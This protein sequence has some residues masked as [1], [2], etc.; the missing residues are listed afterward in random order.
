MHTTIQINR[1]EFLKLFFNLFILF[2]ILFIPFPFHIYPFQET[3]TEVFFK[4]TL[5]IVAET[6]FGIHIT[7]PELSSDSTFM[8]LLVWVLFMLSVLC[9]ILLPFFKKWQC[10]NRILFSFLWHFFLYYLALQLLKYGFDKIFK[11]QFYLPEPNILYT[12]LGQ[13]DKDM[14]FWSCMGTS[15][16]YNI[17]LGMAEVVSALFMFSKR[18]RMLG[19]LMTF[20]VMINVVAINFCFDISV[21]IYSLFLLFLSLFLLSR[22]IK[23]LYRFLI[24]KKNTSL[25]KE[26]SLISVFKSRFLMSSVKS[27]V[28]GIIFIEALYP[29]I[30]DCNFNDDLAQRPFLHGA[31]EVQQ[32][33]DKAQTTDFNFAPVKRFFIHRDG[34]I[35][36]QNAKDEMQDYKLYI[37]SNKKQFVLVDYQ[38][39]LTQYNFSYLEKDSILELHCFEPDKVHSLKGKLLDWKRLPVLQNKFHW[40]IDQD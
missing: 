35:I 9:S 33:I 13:L 3:I 7:N 12:P 36:F 39:N 11:A 10:N 38:D 22:Q 30:K 18:F 14:L 23:S 6:V 20:V 16:S 40:T 5:L 25:K 19:L 28:I 29:Y 17:F 37:D 15:Y 1:F 24:L 27:V 21:K 31:Y 32:V 4:R 26:P 8:Y 2:G 34:Y